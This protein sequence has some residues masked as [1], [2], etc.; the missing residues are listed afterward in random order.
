MVSISTNVVLDDLA[1]SERT[2]TVDEPCIAAN[3]KTVL[4][5]GNWYST[6]ST[7]RGQTWTMLD[8]FTAFPMVGGNFCCD[9]LVWY[10]KRRK[11]WLWILQYDNGLPNGANVLR[12]A[13]SRTSAPGSLTWWDFSPT[14]VDV[15]WRGQ[16][17]D[18]PDLG[19]TDDHVW[20]SSNVFDNAAPENHWQHS[21][22][23]RI[24]WS[25]M[26]AGTP[27][28]HLRWTSDNLSAPRLALGATDTMWFGT[29]GAPGHTE[30]FSWPDA[31]TQASTWTVAVSPW[32]N[33]DYSSNGPD[34]KPWLARAD[35]RVT[36]AWL[37]NGI[38]GFAWSAARRSGR[39]HPYVRCVRIDTTTLDVVDEP[40]L[41]SAT[42]AW[43]YPA[44]APNT[45]GDIGMAA[46][47]GGPTHPAHAVGVFDPATSTWK[48]SIT[49]TSTH[50]PT[51][52]KWGDYIAC[53]PHP[54]KRHAWITVGFVLNGGDDRTAVE[55]RYISW[56]A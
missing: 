49:A 47:F 41:W 44:I 1:T 16:W 14:D 15:S 35:D 26:L 40:D 53:K 3:S 38:V 30:V 45:A 24:P 21:M 20:L 9:Q 11:R 31:S 7:D 13:I 5:T 42:G 34:G 25:E 22:V 33:A 17:F 28:S 19:E 2:S 29:L 27:L 56:S 12:L 54:T 50:A 48:M 37:E 46:F 36:G 52:G 39:P 10:S 32:S 23:L 18:F 8:P 4:V 6:R 51:E 55:P 43:A